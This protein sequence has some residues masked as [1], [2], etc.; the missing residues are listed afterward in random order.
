MFQATHLLQEI[1]L[2]GQNGQVAQRIVEEVIRSKHEHVTIPLRSMG[3]QAVLD[4]HLKFK[5]VIPSYVSQLNE[6]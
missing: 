4:N 3:E 6:L 1:G 5:T 2:N